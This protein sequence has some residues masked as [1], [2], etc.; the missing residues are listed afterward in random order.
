MVEIEEV[1]GVDRLLGELTFESVP[2]VLAENR[3]LADGASFTVDLSGLDKVDSAG[4][5]LLLGWIR[6]ARRAGGE[7]R[8]SGLPRQ[9]R[10]L[11]RIADIETL[12]DLAH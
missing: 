5:A 1:N 12:F 10:L 9:L 8:F 11:V 7:L 6:R 4:L 3:D 2:R